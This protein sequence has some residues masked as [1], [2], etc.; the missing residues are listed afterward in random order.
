MATNCIQPGH[1]VTVTATAAATAGKGHLEGQLFGIAAAAAEIGESVDLHMEGVWNLDKASG[2][3][4]TLGAPIYYD[5][6]AGV[7]HTHA[8]SDSNSAGASTVGPIGVAVAAAGAGVT[9]VAVR[10]GHV[11]TLV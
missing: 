9:K 10:L 11:P 3:V 6:V 1:V 5:T 7:A 4:V 8:D 2:D